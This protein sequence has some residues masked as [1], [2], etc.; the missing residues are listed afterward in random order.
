MAE[1]TEQQEVAQEISDVISRPVGFGED[2][3]EVRE[4]LL[5]LYK[6]STC[7]KRNYVG[8]II[9]LIPDASLCLCSGRAHGR[10]GG[11]GTG[12]AG[13]ASFGS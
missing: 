1:I 10:A 13:R 9:T 8:I 3:D 6:Q 5:R 12:R 4:V 2:Y 11:A 7:Y